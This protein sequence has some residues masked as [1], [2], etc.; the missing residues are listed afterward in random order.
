MTIVLP[1]LDDLV[2]RL[3]RFPSGFGVGDHIIVPSIADHVLL[4]Y[5]GEKG[6]RG[7]HIAI[8]F[9]GVAQNEVKAHGNIRK[10]CHTVRI[11][12]SGAAGLQRVVQ[13]DLPGQNLG[14]CLPAFVVLPPNI[15][16]I[17]IFLIAVNHRQFAAF[18]HSGNQIGVELHRGNGRLAIDGS[19]RQAVGVVQIDTPC[20]QCGHGQK[21]NRRHQAQQESG[22][23]FIFLHRYHL[24]VSSAAVWA[25]AI[26]S[27]AAAT[28]E[29]PQQEP[30]AAARSGWRPLSRGWFWLLPCFQ[31]DVPAPK[32]GGC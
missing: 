18:V 20:R 13:R 19:H 24:R 17:R 1:N 27:K 23:G 29:S 28:W 25:V 26:E 14:Y 4:R 3:D 31:S 15:K 8:L 12:H 30:Q 5:N 32:A 7:V 22:Q 16:I 10:H 21:R 9:H 2:I 11:R 6:R